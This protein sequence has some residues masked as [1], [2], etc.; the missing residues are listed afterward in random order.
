[1]YD[2]YSRDLSRKVRTSKRFRAQ[3]GD[4]LSPF[5]PYGYQKDPANKNRLV[6]DPEAASVV[7][8]IF[9]M[10]ADGANTVQIAKTLNHESV[11]TPMQYKRAAGCS[12]TVWPSVSEDNFWTDSAISAIL[13]DERYTGKMI[14]GKGTRDRV[15][16][17]HMVRVNRAEW[18][19]TVQAK[20][21][22]G[23]PSLILQ[24][25]ISIFQIHQ[26]DTFNIQ[27]NYQNG[28][29]K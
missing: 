4:F 25:K 26:L 7:R 20:I 1:M 18:I 16:N 6:V 2:L 3:R 15:G 9:Q 23:G 5:A 13:R 29:M 21:P 28:A 17:P 24:F 19:T 14:Y 11:L 22:F 8:R 10:A 12:R 27:K